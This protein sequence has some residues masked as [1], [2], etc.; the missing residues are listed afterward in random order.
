MQHRGVAPAIAGSVKAVWKVIVP[1]CTHSALLSTD[2]LLH[3]KGEERHRGRANR[4]FFN[5]DIGK[6]TQNPYCRFGEAKVQ[7]LVLLHYFEPY[8]KDLKS[9][10]RPPSSGLSMALLYFVCC[11]PPLRN[12]NQLSWTYN[13]PKYAGEKIS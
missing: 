6:Q 12:F 1:G 3:R 8:V 9:F 5:L 4:V 2:V 7:N 13:S 11:Y 10:W